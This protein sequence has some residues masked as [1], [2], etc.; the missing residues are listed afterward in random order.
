MSDGNRSSTGGYSLRSIG[1]MARFNS[2]AMAWTSSPSR[3]WGRSSVSRMRVRW[4]TAALL[5][6]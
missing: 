1:K 6:L 3:S 2:S 4:T 5:T